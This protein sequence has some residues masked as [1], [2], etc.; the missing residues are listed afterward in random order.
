MMLCPSLT[1]MGVT[2]WQGQRHIG[3]HHSWVP[4]CGVR[5]TG[6]QH[7]I[8]PTAQPLIPQFLPWG[9]CGPFPLSVSQPRGVRGENRKCQS[10]HIALIRTRQ[11]QSCFRL[12]GRLV[13]SY[14]SSS[15]PDHLPTSPSL[16]YTTFFT[17][18]QP[19][20]FP[21]PHPMPPHR[22]FC[23]TPSPENLGPCLTTCQNT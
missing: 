2:S 22:H 5:G 14:I 13:L 18:H 20:H 10:H 3:G 9:N 11:H 21:L 19:S 17:L 8:R 16:P 23:P 7:S 12:P 1:A 4:S 15:T 6:E